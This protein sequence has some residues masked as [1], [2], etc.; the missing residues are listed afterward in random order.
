MRSLFFRGEQ[1][2]QAPPP[3]NGT[4]EMAAAHV[5]LSAEHII[6][7]SQIIRHERGIEIGPDLADRILRECRYERQRP[8]SQ[9]RLQEKIDQMKYG[10]FRPDHQICFAMFLGQLLLMNGYT[11]LEAIVRT[12]KSYRFMI[13]VRECKT[14]RDVASFYSEFDRPL[15]TRKIRER[16]AGYFDPGELS[17]KEEAALA[18]AVAC[19]GVGLR[20]PDAA[21]DSR[22]LNSPDKRGRLIEYW[23]ETA[24]KYFG[25]IV[26]DAPSNRKAMFRRAS[27]L[28]P[29]LE[30]LRK[31]PQKGAEFFSGAALDDGLAKN[32][33]RKLMLI[34]L[35]P[36]GGKS[37]PRD[38]R[39][40]AAAWN[41]Y[42][43]GREVKTIR[44]RMDQPVHLA[45]VS[46]GNA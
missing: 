8:L 10:E 7:L 39:V 20:K 38:I 34:Q 14:G 16:F 22:I 13:C 26:S 6:P 42:F 15:S 36:S 41:A 3:T 4:T 27:V 11:R 40:V 30:I 5:Q 9:F 31:Q 25:E 46:N 21:K 12:G 19:I 32:D 17:E 35:E 43:S 29:A 24:A 23:R 45:G 44:V 1:K 2:D 37:F 28:A 33:P 18:A